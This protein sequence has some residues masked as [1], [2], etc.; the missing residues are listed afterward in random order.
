MQLKVAAAGA[1]CVEVPAHY[2]KRIGRSKV[3]GTI[4]GTVLASVTILSILGRWA[5]HA[6]RSRLANRAR[7]N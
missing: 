2:R 3:T 5:W 7:S 1:R 4:R 6:A